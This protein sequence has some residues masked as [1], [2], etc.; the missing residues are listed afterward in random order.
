MKK[1]NLEIL[2]NFEAFINKEVSEVEKAKE[3][4]NPCNYID[5]FQAEGMNGYIEGLKKS[6]QRLKRILKQK[7]T[8]N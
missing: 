4:L 6:L 7:T 8:S 3:E 2:Q 1:E 5:T